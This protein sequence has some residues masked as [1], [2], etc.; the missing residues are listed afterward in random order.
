MLMLRS[1]YRALSARLSLT[2][3]TV[4]SMNPPRS[5]IAVSQMVPTIRSLARRSVEF[6]ASVCRRVGG[7]RSAPP[8]VMAAPVTALPPA[9]VAK[10]TFPDTL[11]G[12]LRDPKALADLDKFLTLEHSTENL[13]FLIGWHDLMNSAGGDKG[14]VKARIRHLL[15]TF[16]R[17]TSPKQVN[18]S[19]S[20]RTAAI[21]A[22]EEA[23]RHPGESLPQGLG[24]VPDGAGGCGLGAAVKEI[25]KVMKE[26]SIPRFV[27]K[28]DG[29][30]LSPE[31]PWQ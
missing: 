22:C 17:E 3:K 2:A 8:V 30:W 9:V 24:I 28:P 29:N 26:D 20:Q 31:V 10:R 5:Q 16:L 19:G 4:A 25:Y 7:W 18:I 14:V 15:E 1:S 13:E 27:G 12:L 23:L 11:Q 21:H 6:V